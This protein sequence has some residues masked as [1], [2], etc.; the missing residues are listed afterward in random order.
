MNDLFTSIWEGIKSQ[1]AIAG[2]LSAGLAGTLAYQLKSFPLKL[3]NWLKRRICITYEVKSDCEFYIYF[4]KWLNEQSFFKRVKTLRSSTYRPSDFSPMVSMAECD[5]IL[6]P[7]TGN[8][9]FFYK[10]R[11]VILSA[12]EEQKQNG[13][14]VGVIKLQFL[15]ARRKLLEELLQ[16]IGKFKK[17]NERDE[18]K[19]YL[20]DEYDWSL[21]RNVRRR[22]LESIILQSEV[23]TDIVK[24]IEDFISKKDWYHG[25]GIPWRRG[26]LLHGLPGNG[27]TSLVLALASHFN[28][29]IY[30]IDLSQHSL[31]DNAAYRLMT[32]IPH[33]H[34]LLIEDIDAVRISREK[35]GDKG[36]TFS[37]LLNILGGVLSREGCVTFLTTNHK[38][39]LDPALIRPGRIDN[40]IE[41][42]NADR[43]Q[44]QEIA[45]RFYGKDLEFPESINYKYSMAQI[46]GKLFEYNTIEDFFDSL[47]SCG[48]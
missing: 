34:F 45:K 14:N 2:G 36:I 7:S 6:I 37:G 47:L 40:I 39:K 18:V 44:I 23:K 10:K 30:M 28:K 42:K 4:Q 13:T 1:P 15:P 26:Y 21:S 12:S 29:P 32:D 17:E 25:M 3:L 31:T 24:D 16:E 46:Q 41:L 33:D 27:K 20:N 5:N 19:I 11:L 22:S 48:G 8:Y 43:F 9:F 35:A 38:D